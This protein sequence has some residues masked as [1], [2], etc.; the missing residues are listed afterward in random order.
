MVPERVLTPSSVPVTVAS[1]LAALAALAF[2]HYDLV[3]RGRTVGPGA[4]REAA[5]IVLGGWQ[6]RTALV[7]VAAATGV[8]TPVL[9]LLTAVVGT[10]ALA[11]AATGWLAARHGDGGSIEVVDEE[12]V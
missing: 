2:R 5:R 9:W 6:L 4:P 1:A 8:V 11:D 10:V 3:Y 12:E 7:L